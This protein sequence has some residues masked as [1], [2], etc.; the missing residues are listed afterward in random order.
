MT[1]VDKGDEG[2]KRAFVIMPFDPEFGPIYEQL[3]KPALE[4]AGY[5]VSRADSVLDQQNVLRDIVRGI[6]QA[7]LVV[8]E[9]TTRNPNVMYELGLCHGLGIPTILVAQSPEEIPFDLRTYR[10]QIYSTSFAEVHK[11]TSPLKEIAE[12]HRVGRVA[13]GSPVTD[14]IP[15]SEVA[16][17]QRDRLAQ[18]ESRQDLTTNDAEVEGYIDHLADTEASQEEFSASMARVNEVTEEMGEKFQQS[19][20]RIEAMNERP[21]PGT[22][23]EAQQIAR[24]AAHDLDE[25]AMRLE[26]ELPTLESTTERFTGGGL[27][28]LTWL[29][30]ENNAQREQ[31]E[32]QKETLSELLE[33]TTTTLPSIIEFQN[34]MDGLQGVSAPLTRASRRTKS[35]L[36]R[37][38]VIFEKVQSFC[39]T[40]L[41]ILEEKLREVESAPGSAGT[42]A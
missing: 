31:L 28:Y 20:E 42:T 33:T 2:V 7:D 16:R 35:A 25:Y 14:F 1:E 9:L 24:E 23:K 3:I 15:Q 4:E 8:A 41:Q 22:A 37:I 36:N 29:S 19:T 32:S 27:G 40:G 39:S 11:L 17:E 21:G 6:Q 34:V 38:V 13:F 10:T 30:S 26:E 18:P 5:E 12:Q